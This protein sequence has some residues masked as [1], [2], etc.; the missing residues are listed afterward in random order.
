MTPPRENIA[1]RHLVAI[2]TSTFEAPAFHPLDVGSEVAGLRTWLTAGALGDR[3]FD[4]RQF[5]TLAKSPARDEV[6]RRLEDEEPFGP[7]DA[8]VLYVT[9]H[10]FTA[11]GTHWIALHG[12]NPTTAMQSIRTIDLIRWLAA[13]GLDH[14]L[15][16]IDV[17][18]AGELIGDL[19]AELWKEVG[20]RWIVLLTSAPTATAKLGAF[21]GV[22][23]TVLDDVRRSTDTILRGEP[24]L[25]PMW[26][27]GEL[28]RLLHERHRQRLI[29]LDLPY[30]PSVCLPNPAYDA[31]RFEPSVT[32]RARRDLALLAPDVT[33]HWAVR[34]PVR[35]DGRV[36][37]T[38]RAALMHALIEGAT[39]PQGTLV[40]SGRAGSGKSSAL[41]RLVTCSDPGFREQHAE[42]LALAAPVPPEGAVDIAVLAAGKTGEQIAQQICRDL[43][44]ESPDHTSA[45]AFAS[46][47]D[48]ARDAVRRSDRTLTVVIDALDEAVDP[49]GVLR[50]V[51]ARLNPRDA[52][53]IRLLLG[54]RSSGGGNPAT[55]EPRD[56]AT[57]VTEALGARRVS[58]DGDGLWEPDDLRAY[59][60]QVLTQ[61]GSRYAGHDGTALV[62]EIVA[63]IEAAAARSY[64]LA[65]LAAEALAQLDTPL[66]AAHPK[67][68]R[69]LSSGPAQLLA[70]E[71]LA[72]VPNPDER[73]RILTL[74]RAAALSEGRGAPARVI[75]PLLATAIGGD[76]STYGDRDVNELLQHPVSGYLVRDVE[77]GLTVYRPFHEELRRVL[78][79]G[80]VLDA[81]SVGAGRP[82]ADVTHAGVGAGP[83]HHPLSLPEAQRRIAWA[84]RSLAHWDAA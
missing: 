20:D 9:G 79:K 46:W 56:L 47:M 62:P 57:L 58:V 82:D 45:G 29:T 55:G 81:V 78:A 17:C 64:L 31:R 75:W 61:P 77:D 1:R 48:A 27:A 66:P 84:L 73:R 34:T 72:T 2:A 33:K 14:V 54:V 23:S 36:V 63:S 22:L 37:F 15:L 59:A 18:E 12:S 40:V 19:R 74:L 53:S 38:G 71:L 26:F 21:T 5:K 24:Y 65:G 43:G 80:L 70:A 68:Q 67:V 50:G 35:V 13:P 3:R 7:A 41:A 76:G 51:L 42:L 25:Q 49:G 44:A 32:A 39:G 4:D 28:K 10:G 11:L 60:E 30:Q 8:V 6:Q 69:V 83:P 52:P 16:I